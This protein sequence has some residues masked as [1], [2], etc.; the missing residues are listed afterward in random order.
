MNKYAFISVVDTSGILDFVKTLIQY[1][2]NIIATHKTYLFLKSNGYLVT[3]LSDYFDSEEIIQD[4]NIL[5]FKLYKSITSSRSKQ[6]IKYLNKQNINLIDLVIV[7]F[8]D[9]SNL[10]NDTNNIEKTLNHIDTITPYIVQTA[11]KNYKN[12][13]VLVDHI[14]Y[15]F[16]INELHS[17]SVISLNTKIQLAN[18]ALY[19]I[20]L[21][22]KK[23]FNFFNNKSHNLLFKNMHS[24][25]ECKQYNF[26]LPKHKKNIKYESH[27]YYQ[28]QFCN[29]VKEYLHIN[30]LMQ[31]QGKELTYDDFINVKV[32]IKYLKT[33]LMPTCIIFNKSNLCSV[34]SNKF[35][36][37]SYINAYC[38]HNIIDNNPIT[39]GLNKI[40]DVNTIEHIIQHTN[41]KLLVVPEISNNAKIFLAKKAKIIVIL[42]DT[43]KYNKKSNINLINEEHL[44][45]KSHDTTFI[46]KNMNIVSKRKPLQYEI[47]DMLFSWKI[48]RFMQSNSIICCKNNITL[49]ISHGK[50]NIMDS[51]QLAIITAQNNGF[52][53]VNSIIASE[54][55]VS[56]KNYIDYIAKLGIKCLIQPGGSIYDKEIIQTID[57][58]N[59]SMIFTNIRYI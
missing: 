3:S 8:N 18:K 42:Y 25:I 7:N 36:A 33:F 4:I 35:L 1:K 59:M 22:N 49:G 23:I 55:F 28:K 14:D 27:D 47:D 31:I 41:I 40:L 38:A 34:S 37:Q 2:F 15:E 12:I 32:I 16:I 20:Y 53:I 39:I 43:N 13:A 24:N 6:D 51:I 5:N 52:N 56:S 9:L 48:I 45:N 30:K 46:K 57:H 29:N 11:S 58:Y 26:V 10:S 54:A 19:Y 50:I 44:I 21:Y 17:K